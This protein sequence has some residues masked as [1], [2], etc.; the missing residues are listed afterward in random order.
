MKKFHVESGLIYV[1]EAPEKHHYL[2]DDDGVERYREA[3]SLAISNKVLA[4]DQRDAIE[5]LPDSAFD[6]EGKQKDGT[7]DIPVPEGVE[8]SQGWIHDKWFDVDFNDGSKELDFY[9]NHHRTI[10]RFLEA[11]APL[12]LPTKSEEEIKMLRQERDRL[13]EA[14]NLGQ[15]E[16]RAMYKRVGILNSN[17][18]T[19][20]D[21]AL[22]RTTK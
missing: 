19:T 22:S 16:L 12:I 15:A 10:Y 14:L 1:I 21:E 17:V 3:L 5:L 2:I 11:K 18:L 20:I 13:V 8:V 9:N 4:E 6:N 7:H